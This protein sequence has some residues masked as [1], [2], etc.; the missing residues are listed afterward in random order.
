MK[1]KELLKTIKKLDKH[2]DSLKIEDIDDFTDYYFQK[3]KLYAYFVVLN[4]S[5][6]EK[7]KE[8]KKIYKK[9]FKQ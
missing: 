6:P 9:Y 3:G 2:F 1:E 7:F 5:Y 4:R 8:Y